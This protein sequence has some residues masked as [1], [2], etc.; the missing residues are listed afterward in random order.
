MTWD[1]AYDFESADI[2]YDV[3]VSARPDLSDPVI[4]ETGVSGTS[5]TLPA[6]TLEE[7]TWYWTVAAHTDTG[8]SS[9]PMNK[10]QVN[11]IYYPG[12]DILEVTE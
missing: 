11:E 7:G 3:T 9:M 8:K 10:I 4:S 6:D 1:E 12:V 2:T 5:L